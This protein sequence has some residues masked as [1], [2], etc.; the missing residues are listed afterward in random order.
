MSVQ[1]WSDHVYLAQL[2]DE[3]ALSEDLLAL[4]DDAAARKPTPHMVLDFTGVRHLNSSNLSQLLRLRKVAVD[5]E[6]RLIL[7]G[8]PDGV[9]A[10]FLTT[11]LDKVFDFAQDLPTALALTQ[12]P[13]R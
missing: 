1:R 6:A 2:A 7:A 5:G 10:V 12:L 13:R 8:L 9:W 3:P 11:G 4:R